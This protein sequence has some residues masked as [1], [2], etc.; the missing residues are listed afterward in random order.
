MKKKVAVVVSAFLM[1]FALVACGGGS[2]LEGKW[3]MT[4]ATGAD[5]T[6]FAEFEK[7]GVIYFNIKGGKITPELEAGSSLS[8]EEKLALEMIKP[9]LTSMEMNYE[10]LSDTEMKLTISGLGQSATE[11]VNYSLN[12]NTLVIDD[13]TFTR[14]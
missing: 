14:Q 3:K 2:G 4:G 1:L 6:E 7:Y 8:E 5:M 12:G 13:M 9:L 11:T 10:V